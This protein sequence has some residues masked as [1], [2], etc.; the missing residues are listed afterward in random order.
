MKDLTQRVA[1][2]FSLKHD[3]IF[4]PNGVVQCKKCGV[5][6]HYMQGEYVA[7]DNTDICGDPIDIHDLGK[8]LKCFREFVFG[9]THTQL[10]EFAAMPLAIPLKVSSM[11]TYA[12]QLIVL[13]YVASKSAEQ[14]WGN[15]CL[16]KENSNE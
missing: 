11:D 14:I 4:H 16:A 12:L 1:R 6:A 3:Y 8:A 13:G 7:D 10:E 9:M 2:N 5:V 15:C